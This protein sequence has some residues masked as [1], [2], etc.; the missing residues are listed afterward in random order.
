MSIP[1]FYSFDSFLSLINPELAKIKECVIEEIIKPNIDN[2]FL[3]A[4]KYH[5]NPTGQFIIGGPLGDCGVTGRK[6]IV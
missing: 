5:I 1:G 4:T 3:T 6:I 2:K